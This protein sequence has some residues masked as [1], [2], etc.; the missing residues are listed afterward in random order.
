MTRADGRER[1]ACQCHLI[2]EDQAMNVALDSSP[3]QAAMAHWFARIS[4]VGV[5][6]FFMLFALAEGIPPLAQQPLRVQLFFAL[7]GVM[8]VGYAIGWRRPLFGGLTSLLGYGLLNAVELA[9]NH[10]LLGGAFWLFAIPGVL[11]L[12]AA[13]RASRN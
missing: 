2:V 6:A 10:R 4:A 12:I 13:W 9:T 5:F 3:H 1:L 7:W 8:F 11:Y